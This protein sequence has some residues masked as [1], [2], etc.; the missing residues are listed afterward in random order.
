MSYNTQNIQYPR[1]ASN[2]TAFIATVSTSI[3]SGSTTVTGFNTTPPYAV[4]LVLLGVAGDAVR[5]LWTG[6]TP[7]ASVGHR[8]VSGI[9]YTMPTVQYNN[10][11]FILD[12]TGTASVIT[13]SPF[14][15]G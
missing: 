6:A 14:T 2:S 10:S 11:K 8:F 1:P 5:V 3:T 12:G 15:C 7:T 4:D 13:A 9:L